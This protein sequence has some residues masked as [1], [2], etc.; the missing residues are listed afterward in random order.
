MP[1]RLAWVKLVNPM[2]DRLAWVKLMNA[3]KGGHRPLMR[4]LAKALKEQSA[5]I[6]DFDN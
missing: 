3:C 2:P 6:H 1:D 4:E 5:F